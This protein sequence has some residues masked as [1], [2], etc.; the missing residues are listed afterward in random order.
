[1][2]KENLELWKGNEYGDC[3][4]AIKEMERE[5]SVARISQEQE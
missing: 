1:M 5:E 2:L 3:G 4:D